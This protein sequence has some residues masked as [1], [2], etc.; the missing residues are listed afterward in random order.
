MNINNLVP[1]TASPRPQSR[2]QSRGVSRG[3]GAGASR[4]GGGD[5]K[6]DI[7]NKFK[8]RFTN[9]STSKNQID[10]QREYDA[11]MARLQKEFAILDL[12]RDGKITMDELQTFL[13]NKVNYIIF[14]KY[15]DD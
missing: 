6:A 15:L 13:N 12:D 5:A 7:N 1:P 10:K 14:I 4:A 9:I 3:G 11:N 8:D 2:G